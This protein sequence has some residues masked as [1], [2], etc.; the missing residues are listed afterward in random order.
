LVRSK[1]GADGG[2][3]LARPPES[4]TVGDVIRSLSGPL[5]QLS[6]LESGDFSNPCDREPT[7]QFKPIWAEVDAAI[8]SVL[9]SVSFGDLVRQVRTREGQVMYHI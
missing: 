6:C 3:V 1:R 8:S 5:V 2:Y 9:D 7:C 4:I